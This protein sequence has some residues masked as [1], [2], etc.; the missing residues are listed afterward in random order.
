ELRALYQPSDRWFWDEA[1]PSCPPIILG[2]AR[3]HWGVVPEPRFEEMAHWSNVIDAARFVSVE[4]AVFGE[5]PARRIMRA[6]TVA[7]SRAGADRLAGS[8]LEHDLTG[9]APREDVEKAYQRASRNRDKALEQFPPTVA[10][11]RDGVLLYDASSDKIRRER[12]APFY[13]H[14][15]I[16]Y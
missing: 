6:L 10:W 12:F 16:H 4:Q 11:K 13:H 5:E 15:D 2:H 9:V 7:P 8:M 1:S 14:P 3:R